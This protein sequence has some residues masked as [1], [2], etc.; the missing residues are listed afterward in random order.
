MAARANRR[1]LNPQRAN[2]LPDSAPPAPSVSCGRQ[3]VGDGGGGVPGSG[4]NPHLV[5]PSLRSPHPDA[6]GSW[7]APTP[8]GPSSVH[9]SSRGFG[10]RRPLG[11]PAP[12]DPPRRCLLPPSQGRPP[13]RVPGTPRVRWFPSA[14]LGRRRLRVS[15]LTVP[16]RSPK[17][18]SPRRHLLTSSS[19]EP[20]LY[21][22]LASVHFLFSAPPARRPP[23]LD[24]ILRSSHL[25]GH[26]RAALSTP[27][28]RAPICEPSP[29][30]AAPALRMSLQIYNDENVTA[31]K[32]AENCEFL[33]SPPELTGRL[34][35]LRLSQKE[36]VPPKSVLKAMKVSTFC[37]CKYTVCHALGPSGTCLPG[38]LW[39]RAGHC[40]N[41]G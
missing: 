6:R 15:C 20:Y 10:V 19:L 18:A 38:D 11:T 25:W 40:H 16:P 5:P 4:L 26:L 23:L 39:K 34:S 33:F 12:W 32:S 1:Y 9:G 14:A 24:P 28:L 29:T 31:D 37:L 30:P 3:Q 2:G 21:P 7:A 22:R 27:H 35:V 41:S 8:N 17:S 36:N 13:A